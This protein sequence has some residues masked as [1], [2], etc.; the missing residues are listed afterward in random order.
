[1]TNNTINICFASNNKYV[2]FLSVSMISILYNT[3]KI[4]KFLYFR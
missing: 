3:K 2:D 1:M 4:Y